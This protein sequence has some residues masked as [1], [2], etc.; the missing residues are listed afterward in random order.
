M[1]GSLS[2]K[3]EDGSNSNKDPLKEKNNV[4]LK[5]V[6]QTPVFSSSLGKEI[7][8]GSGVGHSCSQ[9]EGPKITTV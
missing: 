1:G 2:T 4:R 8:E 5:A 6:S 3:E 9:T 7:P